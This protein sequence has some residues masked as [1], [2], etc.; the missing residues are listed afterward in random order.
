[1]AQEAARLQE[2]AAQAEA[3]RN[4]VAEEAPRY[5]EP[6]PVVAAEAEPLGRPAAGRHRARRRKRRERSEGVG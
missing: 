4:A 6:E 2:A 1:L 5:A 3:A